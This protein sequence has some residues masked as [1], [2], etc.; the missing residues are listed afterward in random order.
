VSLIEALGIAFTDAF[1]EKH[2]FDIDYDVTS[3][4][5]ET[6]AVHPDFENIINCLC[7]YEYAYLPCFCNIEPGIP[8]YLMLAG[9]IKDIQKDLLTRIYDQTASNSMYDETKIDSYSH[10]ESLNTKSNQIIPSVSTALTLEY[11]YDGERA[12]IHILGS[13]SVKIYSRNLENRSEKYS[14]VISSIRNAFNGKN[15]IIDCEIVAYDKQ[16]RKILPFQTLCTRKRK[17]CDVTNQVNVCVFVFDLL[18]YNDESM[19]KKE[20]CERRELL[21]SCIEEIDGEVQFVQYE[22]FLASPNCN[23]LENQSELI[24]LIDHLMADAIINNCEGIMIKNL[25]EGSEYEAF[26][27]SNNWLKL[28]KDYIR[29]EAD[30]LDL[31]VIGAYNGSGRRKDIFGSFLLA[32]YNS[33]M[34]TFESVCKIG[35]GMTD[36]DLNYFSINLKNVAM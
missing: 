16:E 18:Y 17:C 33:E 13:E 12:Q 36:I 23:A 1:K 31:V 27:R 22:N 9:P 21:K 20:L 30:T 34:N 26:Q 10:Y 19:L 28:K 11:T 24:D 15:A 8:V 3:I 14:D 7:N 4:I 6:Y 5:K 29:G 2:K 25:N 35:N 32:S